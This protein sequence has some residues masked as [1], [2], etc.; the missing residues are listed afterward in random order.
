MTVPQRQL[1]GLWPW[2]LMA[3]LQ[4]VLGQ[5]GLELAAAAA[6]SERSAT[7]A[8]IKVTL[9]KPDSAGK[10][11]MEVEGV[12]AGSNG[13]GSTEGKLMQ[14]HPLSLCNTSDDEQQEAL[15]I[16]IV[17]LESPDRELHPCLSLLK[18]AR[19]ALDRGAQ[20]VIFDVTDDATAAEKLRQSDDLLKPVVLV[21]AKDAETLM[22][23]VNNN[24]EATVQIDVR[25]EQE[26]QHYDVGILL[27]VVTALL[28]IILIFA[29][30]FR[31]RQNRNRDSMQQQTIRAISR[32]QTR[33]YK[34]QC[35]SGSQR[36]RG[37]WESASSSNS[38][39][40]CVICLE[41][42][43]DGQ[44]LR[45][46]SCFHE[47]HKKCVDPWLLQHRTCP[48]CLHNIM[49]AESMPGQITPGRHLQQHPSA[50][51]LRPYPHS[52]PR[53]PTHM[54][55][56]FPPPPLDPATVRYL[57]NRQLVPVLQRCSYSH[58][59]GLPIRQY[60]NMC[61][62]PPF[63]PEQHYQG[64]PCAPLHRSAWSA[65]RSAP[66]SR[67]HSRGGGHSRQD[68]GSCSGGSF[69]TEKSGYLADG[70]GSDSS[71]GPCHG[72][73]SDSVLNC[74]DVS[75]QA[76]Y[77]SWST[78][79]SSLS[80]DYDPFVYC[81]ESG[82]GMESGGRPRSLDSMVN[83]TGSCPE[84]QVFN[85]VHFHRHRHH[86]YGEG[87]SSNHRPARSSDRELCASESPVTDGLQSR[88]GEVHHCQPKSCSE[89]QHDAP[90]LCPCPK[91]WHDPLESPTPRAVEEGRDAEENG[92]APAMLPLLEGSR[93]PEERDQS[94]GGSGPKPAQEDCLYCP[95]SLS[96][97]GSEE[98]AET[99]G[100]HTV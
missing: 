33:M 23:L 53:Q 43:A 14:S 27:T 26:G 58:G 82:G 16:S 17:K 32:L 59:E 52:A 10:S 97:Q 15:F 63:P 24:Q 2:L 64:R 68:D 57:P 8:V 92:Q 6:A 54:G 83:R 90:G 19:L 100:Q 34:S 38:S 72:S 62:R 5:T 93:P 45:V 48:L 78:F 41:E 3:A 96:N 56:Y 86:H 29:F 99:M 36:S 18:K 9:L 25:L 71:S 1:A 7:K 55:R 35:R 85:H 30:R 76:V 75:L 80:S 89:G 4:V 40:V 79:R 84:E 60:T 12:F 74:T 13:R 49:E 94:R 70:P 22:E 20:A 87:R 31:C 50:I 51:P 77:G 42:F 39:P 47:F 46:I 69:R 44:N 88:V 37:K 81:G 91:A 95:D 98:E 66:N 11:Y 21:Q 61:C 73:S 28:V 67:H 65:P